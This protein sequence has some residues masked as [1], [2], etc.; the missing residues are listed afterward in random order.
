MGGEDDLRRQRN[1]G[2]VGGAS[3]VEFD[4]ERQSQLSV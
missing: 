1:I 2:M 3:L 4:V